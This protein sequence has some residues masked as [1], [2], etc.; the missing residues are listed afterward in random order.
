MP[1]W[2][3]GMMRLLRIANHEVTV[4]AI[5]DYTPWYRRITFHAPELL[6]ELELFA[7]L[8]LRLWVEDPAKNGALSQRG[9]TIVDPRPEEGS[10]ALDFVL[11]DTAGPAGDWAKQAQVGD[12]REVSFTPREVVLPP[13]TKHL[14]LAGDVTAVPAI[15]SWIDSLPGDVAPSVAIEDDHEDHGLLPLAERPGLTWTWLTAGQGRGS[16][17]ASW[18]KD[19]LRPA[20][21]LYVWAAGEKTLVKALRPVLRE[22]LGLDRSHHFTQFYWIEGKGFG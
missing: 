1:N 12:T 5:H 16:A 14:L 15:N 13:G 8:W 3:R 20:E 18:T 17:L 6:R 21:G 4:T 7:T 19:T 11:H 22:H 2:Q 10:F 9:Y